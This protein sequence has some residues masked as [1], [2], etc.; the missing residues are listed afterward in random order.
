MSTNAGPFEQRFVI[1]S[2]TH[3]SHLPTSSG[4]YILGVDEAG[5]GP[6]L[7]PMVYGVAFCPKAYEEQLEGMGFADSKTLTPQKREELLRV[8]NSDP[9]NLGWAVRVLSPQ[10]ISAGMLR[11]PP[12][13][14]NKQAQDAT[15]LLIQEVLQKGIQLSE[16]YVDALGDCD[17]YTALLSSIF[18][19][20]AFTVRKKADSLFKIVGAA[21][22]GAKVTRDSCLEN[23]VYEESTSQGD[24]EGWG[25]TIGSGYPSDPTTQAWLKSSV[26]P[27]FG[28]PSLVRFSWTT[29]KVLLEKEAHPVKWIDEGNDALIKAFEA[30]KG[31]DRGRCVVARDLGLQSVGTL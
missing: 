19:G 14:L 6:V 26:D 30:E 20:I 25:N 11:N 1:D 22:V 13:N 16:I 9:Y 7:G 12:I 28:F 23:W 29:V 3:H 24:G 18:P 8:L 15:I 5:R 31:R 27:T 21:S 2:Y 17:K 4:P 10:A